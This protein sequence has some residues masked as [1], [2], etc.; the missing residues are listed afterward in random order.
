MA[1]D[2]YH[3]IVYKILAYLYVRLKA[4]E[5]IDS[6][7]L[8]HDGVLFQI[9]EDYWAY[10]MDTLLSR[11]YIR[12]ITVTKPWGQKIIV[13][14]LESAQITPEGITYLCENSTL[15]KA[16]QYLKEIKDITPFI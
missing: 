12:N 14:S 10:I 9:N 16:M 8:R 4:G 5:P 15:R 6:A 1:K 3:V 7:F 11:G 2:D 13:T